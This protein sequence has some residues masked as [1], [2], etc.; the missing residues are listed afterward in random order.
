MQLHNDCSHHR[1]VTSHRPCR[2]VLFNSH[3]QKSGR[4]FPSC[5]LPN[6]PPYTATGCTWST[7]N[8]HRPSCFRFRV[9]LTRHIVEQFYTAVF[10]STT[11]AVVAALSLNAT[12][13]HETYYQRWHRP[14]HRPI[15]HQYR[16]THKTYCSYVSVHYCIQLNF[17]PHENTVSYCS[18]Y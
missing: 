16:M 17:V 4:R 2:K 15:I 3:H 7:A 11:L 8:F 13:F 18:L 10:L 14:I 12:A 6:R 1:S 9:S 5:I